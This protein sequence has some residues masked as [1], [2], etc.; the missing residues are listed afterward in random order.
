MRARCLVA[1]RYLDAIVPARC[2]VRVE[3]WVVHAV[4]EDV[5]LGLGS[6]EDGD[7]V[8]AEQ[9]PPLVDEAVLHAIHPLDLVAFD[10]GLRRL[11]RC[12][13]RDHRQNDG[14]PVPDSFESTHRRAPRDRFQRRPT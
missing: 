2:L 10:A 11:P 1:V 14:Q 7:L 6:I 5:A 8:L 12:Y 13:A 9:V 4:V 3:L